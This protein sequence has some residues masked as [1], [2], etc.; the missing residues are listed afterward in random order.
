MIAV[1]GAI[2]IKSIIVCQLSVFSRNINVKTLLVTNCIQEN[3]PQVVYV[4]DWRNFL[5]WD[6]RDEKLCSSTFD[7]P[8]LKT[9]MRGWDRVESVPRAIQETTWPVY[10]NSLIT[11]SKQLRSQVWDFPRSPS[12]WASKKTVMGNGI[13]CFYEVDQH[14]AP[15]TTW[16]LRGLSW[17]TTLKAM[18]CRRRVI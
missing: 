18:P 4:L 15:W 10:N 16:S 14:Y 12:Y 11:S 3:M 7:L 8:R 5:Q 13:K 6:A 9:S 2:M 1:A 17:K